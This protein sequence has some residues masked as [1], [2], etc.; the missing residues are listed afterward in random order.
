[1]GDLVKKIAGHADLGEVGV[2]LEITN[3][4]LGNTVVTVNTREKIKK[5]YAPYIEI[6][7]KSQ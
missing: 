4:D 2:I 3:N 6:I 5:W 1:M 7:N